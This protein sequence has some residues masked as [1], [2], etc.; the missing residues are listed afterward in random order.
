MRVVRR[1]R[2]GCARPDA[3]PNFADRSRRLGHLCRTSVAVPSCSLPLVD[4]RESAERLRSY[5]VDVR[6]SAN[7]CPA[8]DQADVGRSVPSGVHQYRVRH[9]FARELPRSVRRT[10]SGFGDP[11]R[12]CS[13]NT[14]PAAGDQLR[15]RRRDS[16][17]CSG[18]VGGLCSTV[19]RRPER[20]LAGP[21]GNRRAE[22]A[23]FDSRRFVGAAGRVHHVRRASRGTD[24]QPKRLV[25][26]AHSSSI[27]R[28]LGRTTRDTL[29]ALTS[30]TR[31]QPR[32][33]G[34][35]RLRTESTDRRKGSPS[36]THS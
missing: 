23:L 13:A 21:R 16:R 26:R 30:G 36:G 34:L 4:R 6:R 22:C 20:V 31:L 19:R 25:R 7:G 9:R 35:P 14:R 28:L 24:C 1:G 27:L 15:R 12:T 29:R 17:F 32:L 18:P 2:G 3:R 10:H 8:P 11:T 33:R 5:R